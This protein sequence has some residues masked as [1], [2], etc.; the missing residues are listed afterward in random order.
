MWLH[1]LNHWIKEKA[2]KPLNEALRKRVV[3]E[4]H[5]RYAEQ[6][7]IEIDEH[8]AVSVGSDGFYVQAWVWVP[9]LGEQ[10]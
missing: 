6:G 7:V 9:L 10:E 2:M 5:Y 1:G 8:A 3:E 4:A